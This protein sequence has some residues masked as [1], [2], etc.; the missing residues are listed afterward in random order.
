MTALPFNPSDPAL[1][2]YDPDETPSGNYP[3]LPDGFYTVTCTKAE[4]NEG[5]SA[6]GK[7][8]QLKIQWQLSGGQ[9]DTQILFDD[10]LIGHENA[11]TGV[12]IGRK[13]VAKIAEARG[14]PIGDT[15]DLIGT[16]I[17]VEVETEPERKDKNNPSK[18]HKARNLVR[19]YRAPQGTAQAMAQANG[20][21]QPGATT[22]G[23][24]TSAW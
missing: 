15:N 7:Y 24:T 14:R 9:F 21:A 18:T 22:V 20:A 13:K 19:D 4:Q 5:K 2:G 3:I 11:Q 8:L 1:Q 10:I 6:K 17:D 23:Q 12:Q 16:R